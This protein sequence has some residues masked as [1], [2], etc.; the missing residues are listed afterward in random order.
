MNSII[1]ARKIDTSAITYG[2]PKALDSGGR[3]VYVGYNGGPLIIQTPIM[4]SPFGINKWSANKGG[5][6]KYSLE[7]SFRGMKDKPSLMAFYDKLH[8]LDQKIVQDAL[9]NCTSWLRKKYTTTEVFHALYAKLIRYPKDKE[10]GEITDKYPP[11]FRVSLPQNENEITC[12]VYN[13]QN[14][15][16]DINE[17]ETKGARIS[18]IIK[19]SGIWIA[20]VKFGCSWK[21]VQLKV[22]PPSKISGFSFMELEEREGE[23]ETDSGIVNIDNNVSRKLIQPSYVDDSDDEVVPQR[24]VRR[25]VRKKKED[26]GNNHDADAD[27][28]DDQ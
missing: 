16:V 8:N 10:T 9:E 12:E 6:D 17:I 4:H 15:L 25:V 28:A 26:Q 7:L 22:Y 21:V 23:G 5:N 20:G 18:A 1:L 11:T 2:S 13:A 27:D 19:C 14:Q 24:Q 3:V